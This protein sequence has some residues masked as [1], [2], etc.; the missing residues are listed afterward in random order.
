MITWAVIA[1]ANDLLTLVG[2]VVVMLAMN[3]RLS[4]LTFLV[5][6]AMVAATAIYRRHIRDRFHNVRRAIARVTGYV[7]ENIVGVRVVQAFSRQERNLAI[8]CDEI[9]KNN[10][11]ANLRAT[12]FGVRVFPDGGFHREPGR[13]PGRMDRRDASAGPATHGWGAR[14]VRAVYRAI[15]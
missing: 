2:I 14:R 3:I 13:W 1:V 4:L 5:L 11:Q 9:D 8:F 7:S 12:F 6:P 10:L 15:L